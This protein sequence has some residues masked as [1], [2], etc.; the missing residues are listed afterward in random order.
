MGCFFSLISTAVAILVSSSAYATTQG[1]YENRN[2]RYRSGTNSQ[3]TILN[4]S[5]VN[6][7]SFGKLFSASVDGQVYAQPLYVANVTVPS[8]G[9]SH[10]LLLVA[11]MA[12]TVFAFDADTGAQIWKRDYKSATV[13][14]MPNVEVL[15]G[16]I[17]GNIDEST[18]FGVLGTPT[19][20]PL[21]GIMYFVAF[22]KEWINGTNGAPSYFQ[23]LRAINI[24]TGQDVTGS[25][26]AITASVNNGA[27]GSVVF[28]PQ[29]QLQRPG[30]TIANGQV[31]V[32]WGSYQDSG[33]WNGW[34]MTFD[35]TTLKQTGAF[36]TSPTA[37]G[38][39]IWTSGRAP[40]VLANGDAVVFSGNSKNTTGGGYD[41]KLNFSESILQLRPSASGLSLIN[42]WT[43]QNW[44]TLDQSDLDL[45]AAGPVII[46]VASG[47]S[48]EFIAGG[49]KD[50]AIYT[51]N[52]QTQPFGLLG[53]PTSYLNIGY[54][55][56]DGLIFWDRRASGGAL[57]MYSAAPSQY[58]TG[59]T[60]TGSDFN[61]TPS[62]TSAIVPGSYPGGT[63][64]L[65][66]NG[67]V[68]GTGILWS[69]S[70]DAGD[71]E[72]DMRSGVLRAFDADTLQPLWDSITYSTDDIGLFSKFTPPTI[73][74]GKVYVAS[75]SGQVSA[76]GLLPTPRS[77]NANVQYVKLVSRLDPTLVMEVAGASQAN[78]SRI[79][80][81]RDAG[82][83][84]QRWVMVQSANGVGFF[85]ALNQEMA[86]DVVWGIASSGQPVDLWGSNSTKAQFWTLSQNAAGYTQIISAAGRNLALGVGNGA[87]TDGS[88]LGIWSLNGTAAQDWLIIREPD[89]GLKECSPNV[90]I[91]SHATGTLL[92]L[93]NGAGASIATRSSSAD[94][95][96][97]MSTNLNGSY[98]FYS[99]ASGLFL[100]VAGAGTSQSASVGGFSGSIPNGNP[101]QN[102]FV[103]WPND[104]NGRSDY[105][106]FVPSSSN[107]LDMDVQY[108]GNSDGTPVWLWGINGTW[109]Q[110]WAILDAITG[111]QCRFRT[112]F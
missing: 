41:G 103:N 29:I 17:N 104:P 108:G 63:M 42:A 19:I 75:F 51:V 34:V 4:T 54:D 6:Q 80:L 93:T 97:V 98:S 61:R 9:G 110:D 57:Q 64:S 50:G 77:A 59:W 86:L 107:Q 24:A 112:P 69:V 88:P 40:A 43:P 3:E 35:K 12:D 46:P 55:Q 109:P 67:A 38:A 21:T 48:S 32:C 16:G 91:K 5:N 85:S 74:N 102:W 73:A 56:R 10:N 70:S 106:Q 87:G 15:G 1:V 39:G 14:A 20:D 44:S 89:G 72:L 62:V 25:G 105:M 71:T 26:A 79:Q 37:L 82:W 8:A 99:A 11:T 33:N 76:F 68:S 30:L 18:P 101:T 53:S 27:G 49:G 90:I 7:Q 111:Q 31:V 94:Q 23:R 92:T 66:S 100:G 96:F 81:G 28:N 13:V 58:I 22:T 45:G 60:W 65:S 36:A 95:V 78:Q 2:D 52:V 83:G 47:Q 84:R